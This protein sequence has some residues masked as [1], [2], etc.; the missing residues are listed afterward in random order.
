[1]PSTLDMLKI[2]ETAKKVAT[3]TP[4][5]QL[6]F[7][8]K[9]QEQA[10][11]R[12]VEVAKKAEETRVQRV[13]ELKK[14]TR[15][16]NLYIVGG[17]VVGAVG[18]YFIAKYFKAKTMGLV[19]STIGGSFAVGVPIILATRKKAVVRREEQKTLANAPIIT[20]VVSQTIT[21]VI[22]QVPPQKMETLKATSLGTQELPSTL[23]SLSGNQP[24]KMA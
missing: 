20:P 21:D 24:V 18:G 14:E 12:A 19:L 6:A 8:K 23:Q 16:R 10:N 4:E 22:S 1:M 9:A 13:A 7:A 11:L 15:N 17:M 2:S 5:Q 3:M